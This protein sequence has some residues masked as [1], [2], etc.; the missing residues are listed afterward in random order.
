MAEALPELLA[1][2]DAGGSASCV[3]ANGGPSPFAACL[4]APRKHNPTCYLGAG[5]QATPL[6]FDPAENLLGVVFGAKA[7]TLYPPCD[8]PRLY[9]AGERNSAVV[10]SRVDVSHADGHARWAERWPCLRRA[11][12][13]RATVNK[14][15]LLYLPCGWWHA[16][17][18][19]V[20]PNLSIN[21]WFDL[22]AQKQDTEVRN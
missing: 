7:L 4:G 20:E 14:G 3:G 5:A 17:R 1:D 6:H 21:W 2:M 15:D 9:P 11:T 12:P 10:Y 16:V 18:G 13:H 22:H 19:S 8:A